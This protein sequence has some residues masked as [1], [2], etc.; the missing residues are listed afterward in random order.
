MIY[1]SS[2]YTHSDKNI[3]KFRIDETKRFVFWLIQNG[4]HPISIPIHYH[5]MSSEYPFE[6]TAEFWNNFCE[7]FLLQ[8]NKMFV[9]MLDGWIQSVG[10]SHEINIA[11]NNNIPII[12]Y[13][14]N[15]TAYRIWTF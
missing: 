15:E 10:V 2:P 8:S 4:W 11:K 1:I 12:Y 3:V 7:P 13:Q 5:D 14:P 9:L 6:T